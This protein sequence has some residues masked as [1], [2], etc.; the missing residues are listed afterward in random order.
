MQ[1]D[2]DISDSL[3]ALAQYFYAASEQREALLLDEKALASLSYLLCQ[4]A[5]QAVDLEEVHDQYIH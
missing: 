1:N 3:C 2:H 5:L 4:L